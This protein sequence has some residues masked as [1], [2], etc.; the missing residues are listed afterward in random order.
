MAK[1]EAEKAAAKAAKEAEKAAAE[2]ATP[3]GTPSEASTAPADVE[4]SSSQSVSV[5]NRSGGYVRTYSREEHGPDYRKLAA[6][7]A[8]KIAGTVR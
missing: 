3:A 8:T 1:T 5:Y 2:A 4:V 6:G 7:Y